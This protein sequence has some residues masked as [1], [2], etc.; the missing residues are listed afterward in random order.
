LIKLRI[1]RVGVKLTNKRGQC[2]INEKGIV[3]DSFSGLHSRSFQLPL[4]S[5]GGGDLRG[6]AD[7]ILFLY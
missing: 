3:I 5:A 4:Q 6:I 1:K 7:K 2:Q